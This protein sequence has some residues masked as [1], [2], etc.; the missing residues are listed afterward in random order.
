MD[1]H[2]FEANFERQ[3]VKLLVTYMHVQDFLSWV[4]VLAGEGAKALMT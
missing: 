1:F 3:N 4:S 2:F